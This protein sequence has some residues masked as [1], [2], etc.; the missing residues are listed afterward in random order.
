[1]KFPLSPLLAVTAALVASASSLSAAVISQGATVIQVSG[2]GGSFS[3]SENPPN[4][5]DGTTNKYYSS[6]GL[7]ANTPLP[8]L[9]ITPTLTST[10]IQSVTIFT[11]NDSIGRDPTMISIFGSNDG[12]TYVPIALN[13][14]ISLPSVGTNTSG[15]GNEARNNV[16][17]VA[18]TSTG[19][20]K[21][22]VGFTN[23]T[24]YSSYQVRI[25]SVRTPGNGA[26]FSELQLSTDPIPEP[27]SALLALI[28]GMGFIGLRRR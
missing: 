4:V 20:Y 9:Q 23:T 22:S 1:M 11:G 5:V 25:D 24:A 28:G 14:S 26:Q 10:I 6:Q 21:A 13:L 19:L 18:V 2:T 8:T 16:F 27:T 3:G 15:A 12:V 7:G 17:G